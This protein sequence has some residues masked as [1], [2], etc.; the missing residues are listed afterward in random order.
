M[1]VNDFQVFVHHIIENNR[2]ECDFV[3]YKKSYHQEDKIL[4][5]ICAYA[6]NFMNRDYGYLFIGIEEQ[7]D[8]TNGLK[9]V[10]IRPITGLLE[11]QLEV[12]EN[13]IR[14]LFKYIQPTPT[15]HFIADQIDDKW[16][17]VVIVDQAIV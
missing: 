16:Y 13:H 2:A 6:N 3:E 15:C 17:L 5:T 9:A 4:K 12:A 14:S 8:I 11:G 7:N 10:P 1:N